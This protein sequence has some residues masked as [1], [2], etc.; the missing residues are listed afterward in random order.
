MKFT[1]LLLSHFL[2]VVFYGSHSTESVSDDRVRISGYI[3][4]ADSQ[5]MYVSI[6]DFGIRLDNDVLLDSVVLKDGRFEMEVNSRG[7]IHYYKLQIEGQGN[8]FFEFIASPGDRV[9]YAGTLEHFRFGK[10]NGSRQD[11]IFR[12]FRKMEAE[13]VNNRINKYGQLYREEL[14]F[15]KKSEYLK[16]HQDAITGY[17]LAIKEFLIDHPDSYAP[18]AKFEA[19]VFTELGKDSSQILYDALDTQVKNT[20]IGRH[21]EKML[22]LHPGN[23]STIG[24]SFLWAELE[25]KDGQAFVRTKQDGRT[26]VVLWASW[27][28]PCRSEIPKLKEIY[29]TKASDLSIISISID[30]NKEAWY[31]AMEQENMP[32]EQ[33]IALQGGRSALMYSLGAVSIPQHYLIDENDVIVGAWEHLKNIPAEVLQ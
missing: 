11:S 8:L 29:A 14:D 28:G 21:I 4:G 6:S 1:Y 27:C 24:R 19:W 31:L 12:E 20:K 33:N 32:W 5:K 13:F 30:T 15:T 18:L 17:K 26:L 3:D 10:I 2:L 22:R 7:E 16:L 9:T 23:E 25:T